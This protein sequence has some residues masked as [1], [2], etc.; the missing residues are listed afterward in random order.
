MTREE[1]RR[2]I[3]RND[4][5]EIHNP[6][7]KEIDTFLVKYSCGGRE[8]ELFDLEIR[9]YKKQLEEKYAAKRLARTSGKRR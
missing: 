9:L 6:R 4:K 5:G 7:M 3:P 8:L 2:I 1:L